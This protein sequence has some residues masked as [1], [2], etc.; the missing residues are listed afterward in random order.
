[1]KKI[2]IFEKKLKI[3]LALGGGGPKGLAH[4]GI[5]K[6]LEENNIPIDFIAGTS[7]GAMVGG[8]YAYEKNI[9]Q[10]EKMAIDINRRTMFSLLDLSFSQGVIGGRKIANF[11]KKNIDSVRFD[12]LKVPFSAVATNL[13]SGEAVVMNKG[14][15]STAIRASISLP[16]IFKPIRRDGIL[17]CDGGLSSP[18]P[19]EVVKN[20]GA[21][22]VIAVNLN[23]DYFNK[24]KSNKFGFYKIY[25]N[26]SKILLQNLAYQNATRADVVINPQVGNARWSNLLNGEDIILAGENIARE[27]MPQLKK[28]IEKKSK[29][30]LKKYL[31]IFIKKIF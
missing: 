27:M 14:D 13:K 7:M 24:H 26:S 2:K 31:E 1:M 17:L 8:F 23:G 12:D 20:M 6:V 4:I 21:D 29:I 28:L 19:V 18:V 15:V 10:V 16:L 25:E 11:I 9:K 5:I 3:G 30:S 22:L